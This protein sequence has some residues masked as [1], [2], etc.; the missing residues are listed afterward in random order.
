MTNKNLKNLQKIAENSYY[1][2]KLKERIVLAIGG[3]IGVIAYNIYKNKEEEKEMERLRIKREKEIDEM[4]KKR[5][6]DLKLMNNVLDDLETKK[7][8]NKEE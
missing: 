6:E 3:V 4:F 1:S 8:L 7:E 5:N 2:R